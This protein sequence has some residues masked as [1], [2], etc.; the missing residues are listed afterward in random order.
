MTDGMRREFEEEEF[1]NIAYRYRS[2]PLTDPEGV[3]ARY[4]ELVAH[5]RELIAAGRAAAEKDRE[6]RLLIDVCYM[7]DDE[8]FICGIN[9]KI[10]IGALQELEEA[11]I[12]YQKDEDETARPCKEPGGYT[13][14]AY[15]ERPQRGEYGRI[16]IAGYWDLTLV[17]FKPFEAAIDHANTQGADK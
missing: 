3:S 2:W 9:G 7:G 4:E 13:F 5:V 11:I 6:N 15:Y 14:K 12:E 10:H 16:E 8:T 1:N 17:S